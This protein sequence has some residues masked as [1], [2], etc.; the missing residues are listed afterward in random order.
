MWSTAIRRVLA[1]VLIV[2]GIFTVAMPVTTVHAAGPYVV[3]STNTGDDANTADG[4]CQTAT[5]GEC[6][7]WAAIEQANA[8]NSA[9]NTDITFN[10]TTGA[11]PVKT[12]TTTTT[13]HTS[14][15]PLI[16]VPVTINGF[17][18]SGASAGN[19]RIEIDC[20]AFAGDCLSFSKGTSK[21]KGLVINH[22]SNAISS[23]LNGTNVDLIVQGNYLGTTP[24][25]TAASTFTPASAN[26][27]VNGVGVKISSGS[28]TIGGTGAGEGN[29]IS[30]FFGNAINEQPGATSVMIQG[31]MIGT[32]AAGTAAIT[33][34]G[35]PP[36]PGT[37]IS[38][39]APATIGGPTAA[40][41][42]II[43]GWGNRGIIVGSGFTGV[44]VTGL[45]TI[46]NNYIGTDVNGTARVPNLWGIYITDANNVSIKDNLISGNVEVGIIMGSVNN[47]SVASHATIT[48]NII[49]PQKDGATPIPSSSQGVGVFVGLQNKANAQV[50]GTNPG[51]GNII[52]FN[53]D[54]R[55]PS[56]CAPTPSTSPCGGVG[57]F[58]GA[59]ETG[60]TVLGNSIFN[61]GDSIPTDNA[62]IFLDTGGNNNQAAPTITTAT[63][64]G[65]ASTINGTLHSTATTTFRIEF[66]ET[67]PP[68]AP[69]IPEGKTFRGFQE[70]TT[71][72]GG[73]ASFSVTSGGANFPT[74]ATVGQYV[75]ATA[76]KL[77]AGAGSTPVETSIFSNGV[78]V[79]AQNTTVQSI[80][81]AGASPTDANS[82]SWTVTFADPVSSVTA[83][84]FQTN[85]SGLAGTSPTGATPV[86]A[87]PTT[88]WTVT[89]STGTG[90]GTLGLDMVNSTGMSRTVTNLP[91]T[92]GETYTIDRTLTGFTVVAS[93]TTVTAGGTVD[94]TVT[95]LRQGGATFTS[96]TGT[97]HFTSTDPQATL[98]GDYTF[99]AS[100]NGVHT[101]NGVVVLKTAGS[102]TVTA[103]DGATSGVSGTIT[104]N[105]GPATHFKVVAPGGATAGIAFNFTVTAQDQ[106]DNTVTG[107]GGTVSFTSSDGAATLPSP[108]T[109]ASGVGT[110]PATLRTTGA[111]T[112]T[113][114]DTP[115][116]LT[117]TSGTITV[118]AGVATHFTVSAPPNA[119]A[120]TAFNFT[121]TAL[122]AS[123]NTVTGYGGTVTFTST[124][125][126]ATL[127]SGS[128]L[129]N[130][131]G[132]FP[133]TLKTAG[134]QTITA[135]DTPNSLTGTSG[136]IIVSPA[137]AVS[138]TADPATTPQAAQ[139]GTAFTVPLAAVVKDAF[140]NP[141]S[142]VGVTFTAPGAGASG[143]FTGS[144]LTANATTN[145]SG[146]ATAPAFT[147]NSIAGSYTVTANRTTTPFATAA[148]FA[149]TNTAGPPGTITVIAGSGQTAAVLTAF[150]TNLQ[151]K[152][153]DGSNNPL[154]GVVVTFTAPSSGASGTFA[155]GV[156]TAT[157]NG[158][159]IVTAPTFTANGI[160]GSY[161][162]TASAAGVSA[163]VVFNLTNATGAPSAITVVAGSGQSAQAT[164]AF[165][166]A[167]QAKVTDGSGNPV[168]GISVTFTAPATGA[169]GTFTGGV[170]TATVTTNASGVATAPIFTANATIGSYTVTA[171]L[172][173]GPL[174]TAASFSLSN[175]HGAVTQLALTGVIITTTG[176]VGQTGQATA[177]ATF[178]DGSTQDVSG[179]ATWSSSDPNIATVDNTGKVTFK[180]QGTVTITAT[181]GGVTKSVQVT[182]GAGTPVGVAPVPAPASRPGA[183][184]VPT[185]TPG[186]APN[187][188]PAP[189]TGP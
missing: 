30:A 115:N 25:G 35:A 142:G 21:I 184:G 112:I 169:S 143:T 157:T 89:A 188:A 107:Y 63:S 61:N 49:G 69:N 94:I 116:S 37:A 113:A 97:V 108:G 155:G 80:V 73:D 83:S 140:G 139:I 87:E 19:L 111:Q 130:G 131:I 141:V 16:T 180:G 65:S 71:D 164:T 51:E 77:T 54:P 62:G 104:V 18:Q 99:L 31:N 85:P 120:G 168:N 1:C 24:D 177:T 181:L 29:V 98:P 147:A 145:A 93:P 23:A 167:L 187:P 20:R 33:P 55:I 86:G 41:R 8:D 27:G 161:T 117:G 15:F 66:F 84:N 134:T 22:A 52:A 129:T 6:T 70:V 138:I 189:R 46:Q 76:T 68:T 36:S 182:V 78:Q 173:S 56:N 79:Q 96:Y 2:T 38:I 7:L 183:A 12:I 172:T 34:F 4:I 153:T 13:G 82:V 5:A 175:T 127:P 90:S 150:A 103:A 9:S 122:D 166:T 57:V 17:S 132:T 11:T 10:I 3:N 163:P 14:N 75:T 151:V 137:A 136:N 114:T 92:T 125:P 186:T 44:T 154:S 135:T 67:P 50:G 100:D 165:A 106:F 133:A 105:P 59:G 72:A 101:F 91:F 185:T 144:V 146:V 42:N 123:N 109:L 45:V 119:T 124:D 179:Q 159:G 95:A 53:D 40:A 128:T 176:K 126:Q 152:V 110:F 171:N 121:V 156:T 174:G 118:G 32:N 88:T 162:V 170:R 102:Q 26:P 39:A 74:A 28:A 58:V 43:S 48:N 158:S 148:S 149:L 64:T 81:R 160:A 60:T 178:A 47:A